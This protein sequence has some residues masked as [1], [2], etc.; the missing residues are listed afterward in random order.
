MAHITDLRPDLIAT[1]SISCLKHLQDITAIPVVHTVELL[2]WAHGGPI[3]ANLQGFEGA[4]TDVP[5]PPP[6][7]VDDYIRS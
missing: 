7:D 6:L 3:P 2:D 5:G 1:G 4:A